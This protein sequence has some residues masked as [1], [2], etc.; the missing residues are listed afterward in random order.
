MALIT[1][2]AC[3]CPVKASATICPHCDARISARDLSVPT[4]VGVIALGLAAAVGCGDDTSGGG[5]YAAAYGVP[6]TGGG[7][8][9]GEAAQGGASAGGGGAGGDSSVGGMASFYGVPGTGG[10]GGAGGN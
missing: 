7:A 10:G 8:T 3:A 9:G 6:A 5:G 4:A 1:C 2:P